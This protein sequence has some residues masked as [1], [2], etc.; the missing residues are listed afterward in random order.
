MIK[1]RIQL[2]TKLTLQTKTIKAKKMIDINNDI[3]KAFF[4]KSKAIFL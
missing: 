1:E 2:N 3:N 4:L